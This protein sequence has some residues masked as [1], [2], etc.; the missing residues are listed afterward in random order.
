M[1]EFKG[2]V[3]SVYLKAKDYVE[4]DVGTGAAVAISSSGWEDV[5][6]VGAAA[7]FALSYYTYT[8]LGLAAL[9]SSLWHAQTAKVH[10]AS[11]A[12][13]CKQQAS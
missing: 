9:C 12:A 3:D 10:A 11:M 4:L 7:Q 2:P 1:V 8:K 5:V 6:V 13:T